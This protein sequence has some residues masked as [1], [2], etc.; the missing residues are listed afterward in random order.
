MPLTKRVFSV[1]PG[2]PFLPTLVDAL[3]GGLFG[4]IPGLGKD[5]LALAAVT[6]LVPTRRAARALGDLFLARA[7][8]GVTVLPRIKP[9]GHVDEEEHLL[10]P[11][12]E[13]SARRHALPVTA[14]TL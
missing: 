1:A 13:T 11:S 3:L 4:P 10:A 12:H 14:A 5:P 7:A 6:I 2:A 9:I 8:N